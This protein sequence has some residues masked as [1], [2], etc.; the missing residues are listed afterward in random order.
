MLFHKYTA[1]LDD[2]EFVDGEVRTADWNN[3]HV[4]GPGALVNCGVSNIHF[5]AVGDLVDQDQLGRIGIFTRAAAGVFTA[6]FTPIDADDVVANLVVSYLCVVSTA[7]VPAAMAAWSM[8]ADAADGT[9]TLTVL[10]S[11]A[12]GTDPSG[13]ITISVMLYGGVMQAPIIS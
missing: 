1:T 12:A 10:D 5:D 13:K 2:S 9:V 6:P 11:A 7:V 4:Y 3:A 8:S